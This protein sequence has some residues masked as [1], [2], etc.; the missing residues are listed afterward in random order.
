MMSSTTSSSWRRRQRKLALSLSKDSI[1]SIYINWRAIAPLAKRNSADHLRKLA[2]WA[3]SHHS[4]I[5]AV[6]A[7]TA[8]SIF[9]DK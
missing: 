7:V 2:E 5:S 1:K 3:K 8:N 9:I 6:I 4:L